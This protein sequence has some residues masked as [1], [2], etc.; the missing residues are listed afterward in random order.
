MRY[1]QVFNSFQE[2]CN[3]YNKDKDCKGGK[4]DKG[5]DKGKDEKKGGK[6]DDFASHMMIGGMPGDDTSANFAQAL[7]AAYKRKFG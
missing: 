4:C 5:K 6:N 1:G 7:M 2:L 3:E